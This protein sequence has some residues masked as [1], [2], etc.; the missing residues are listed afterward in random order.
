MSI[1][2]SCGED[3]PKRSYLSVDDL[4]VCVEDMSAG[5]GDLSADGDDLNAGG[6]V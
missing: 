6:G 3:R 5:G 2:V 1:M 4:N